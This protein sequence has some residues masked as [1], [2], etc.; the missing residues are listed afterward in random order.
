LLPI[1][2]QKTGVY[3]YGY[4]EDIYA[5]QKMIENVCNGI[6]I[7]SLF[8]ALTGFCFPSGKLIIL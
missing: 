1:E 6:G 3:L 2:N 5:V 7:F 4:G 8:M